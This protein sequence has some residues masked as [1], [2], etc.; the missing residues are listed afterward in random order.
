MEARV[1][2]DVA[3]LDPDG[4]TYE[5]TLDDAVLDLN[6][7]FISPFAG[8][9][10]ALDVRKIGRELLVRGSL[11]QDFSAVCSRCGE[12]FDF[13]VKIPDFVSSLEVDEKTEFVDLTDELR[14]SI[15]LGIPTYPVCRVDCR[16]ICPHC[17]KNLNEGPCTC[18]AESGDERWNVLDGLRKEEGN[19]GVS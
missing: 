10:Y 4:E 13:T 9:R 5:G 3:R 2:I 6:D 14:E 15:I 7:R 1:V 17:R 18:V 12:D 8:V 16:G 11:E 19:N